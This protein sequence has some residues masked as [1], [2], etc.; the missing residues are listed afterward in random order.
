[1]SK[2]KAFSDQIDWFY[3]HC[4]A[5][6]EAIHTQKGMIDVTIWAMRHVKN[7]FL[8]REVTFN[9]KQDFANMLCTTQKCM[10]TM[11]LFH[12]HKYTTPIMKKLF[13]LQADPGFAEKELYSRQLLRNV[14]CMGGGTGIDLTRRRLFLPNLRLQRMLVLSP[15]LLPPQLNQARSPRMFLMPPQ[16]HPH[17]TKLCPPKSQ[18]RL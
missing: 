16:L 13:E 6:H 7:H 2:R 15:L 11:S 14:R 18:L 5:H 9:V 1:M 17:L 10:G 4:A 3:T 12:C 8:I